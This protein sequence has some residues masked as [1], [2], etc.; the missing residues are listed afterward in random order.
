LPGEAKVWQQDTASLNQ[1][2]QW[3]STL[4]WL[5][6]VLFGSTML[7]ALLGKVDQTIS[8]RGTLEPTGSVR[9]VDVPSGGVV[10]KVF[11]K[12]GQQVKLGQPLLEIE[13][14]GLTSR[15]RSL[16][17]SVAVY[18]AQQSYL[19]TLLNAKTNL[20]SIYFKPLPLK[21]LSGTE[22]QSQLNVAQRESE[23]LRARFRQIAI[24]EASRRQTLALDERI[25]KDLQPLYREG[26]IGRINYLGQLNKVQESRAE[27]A[28]LLEEREKLLGDVAS[29]LTQTTR[30][31]QAARSEL[32]SLNEAIG[33]RTLK[34]PT[35]GKV[36]DLK[37]A[38]AS[39][40]SPAQVLLKLVPANRLQATVDVSNSDIG[41]L[42]VGMP[43]D[44]SVDSFPAGEFGYIKGR[45]ARIGADA[46]P[47]DQKLQAYRFPAK[48]SLEEQEVLV[49]RNHLNLQ[50]G[51]SV[52]AN[53]KIRSRPVISLV[54]DLFTRQLEGVKRFR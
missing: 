29:Q 7:W 17:Y 25:A 15:R 46:L 6:V 44:V 41:F 28:A 16:S 27:L 38:P 3:S 34:A 14:L 37:A 36:F 22:L 32:D 13:A 4:I 35:A 42:K 50:S 18:S 51:M 1:G 10:R 30:Q 53:I 48:V 24:R 19:S 54:T 33:Y 2:T 47:P 43:V 52:T 20:A 11:V 49:G 21:E 45:L 12:E 40:V 9:N 31:L 8:V 5:S 39:V 23:Q 26:G